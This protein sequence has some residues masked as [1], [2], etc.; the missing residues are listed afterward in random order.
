MLFLN[1]DFAIFFQAFWIVAFLGCWQMCCHFPAEETICI[2][3]P[4]GFPTDTF[5]LPLVFIVKNYCAFAFGT[6]NHE[7][8][9]LNP[10][11]HSLCF[12]ALIHQI[13]RDCGCLQ[14][15]VSNPASFVRSEQLQWLLVSVM[16]THIQI[17]LVLHIQDM[18]H[19]LSSRC[20][21]VS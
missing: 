8:H 19:F 4:Y 11:G 10:S 13:H 9:N 16:V 21:W 12:N 2:C 14:W 18:V 17:P 6:C 15:S 3:S 1:L 20:L 7:S 5:L